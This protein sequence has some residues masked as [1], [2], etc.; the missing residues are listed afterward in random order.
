MRS[1]AACCSGTFHQAPILAHPPAK[2]YDA[3]KVAVPALLISLHRHQP[4]TDAVALGLSDP[5]KI[6]TNLLMQA[7]VT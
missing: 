1:I 5:D 6:K 7:Q 3:A 4:L 2:R